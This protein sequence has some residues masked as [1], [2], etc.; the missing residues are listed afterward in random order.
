MVSTGGGL[1]C[2]SVGAIALVL[3]AAAACGS[4]PTLPEET[5]FRPPAQYTLRGEATGTAGSLT[6]QCAMDMVFTWDGSERL[7]ASGRVYVTEGGGDVA[8][9]VLQP[10]GSG[11]SLKPF[12]FS[13]ENHIRLLGGDSLELVTPINVGTG[14]PFYEA[15]GHMT[16]HV[17]GPSSAEGT[18]TCAPFDIPQDSVGSVVGTWRLEGAG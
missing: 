9:D 2:C 4:D 16:G 8:R 1:R 12:L 14:V 11:M 10:D 15:I 3:A 17:S 18:W 6:I 7:E 5:T 13:R